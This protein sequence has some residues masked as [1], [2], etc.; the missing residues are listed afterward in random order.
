MKKDIKD[1]LQQRIAEG[2]CFVCDEV[3]KEKATVNHQVFG[4]VDICI[5]HFKEKIE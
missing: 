5:K 3:L 1:K 4:N 2:R